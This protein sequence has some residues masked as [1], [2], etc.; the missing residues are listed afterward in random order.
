MSVTILSAM[1]HEVFGK[2]FARF[3]ETKARAKIVGFC[4]TPAEVEPL[5]NLLKP[6]ILLIDAK[7]GGIYSFDI[8]RA[9]ISNDKTARIIGITA[10]F[11]EDTLQT[12]RQIGAKGYLLRNDDMKIMEKMIHEV[13]EGRTLFAESLYC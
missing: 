7:L 4:S 2:T 9:I 8:M 12:L 13:M 10:Y 6:D 5:Y 11:Q 3:I 1:R